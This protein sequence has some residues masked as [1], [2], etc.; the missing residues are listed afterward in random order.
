MV[1][2]AKFRKVVSW[3]RRRFPPCYPVSCRLVTV[4]Q[5]RR[6]NPAAD[7][8]VCELFDDDNFPAPN[9]FRVSV[10]SSLSEEEMI[11]TTIHEWSHVLRMHIRHL[12]D[13]HNDDEIFALIENQILRRW[14]E[15]E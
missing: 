6:I 10:V 2:P 8:G 12:G 3:L 9:S 11:T 5:L 15:E 13:I 4:D 14:H 1:D 7:K